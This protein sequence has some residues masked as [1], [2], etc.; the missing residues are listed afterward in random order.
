ME[1]FGEAVI[2][3][4]SDNVLATTRAHF[5]SQMGLSYEQT[6]LKN[7]ESGVPCVSLRQ[8]AIAGMSKLYLS[9]TVLK[10]KD[11]RDSNNQALFFNFLILF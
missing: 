5:L 3:S 7:E 4:D 9:S 8:D 6:L 10:S 2:K 1:R 11:L